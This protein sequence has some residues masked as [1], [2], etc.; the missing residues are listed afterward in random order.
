M[1]YTADEK[2]KLLLRFCGIFVVEKILASP[3]ATIYCGSKFLL[4]FET[5]IYT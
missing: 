2:P 5:A 4:E 3:W 1:I